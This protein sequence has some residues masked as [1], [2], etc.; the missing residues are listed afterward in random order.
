MGLGN[1]AEAR[2]ELALISQTHQNDL[3]VLNLRWE[4]AAHEADWQSGLE[5]ARTILEVAPEECEGWLHQAYALR[6]VSAGGLQAAWEALLP[7][8]EKFPD[9]PTIPYN[10]AC[11]AC[12]MEQMDQARLLLNRAIQ[13]GGKDQIKK[14][15][16][17]DSDLQAL[18]PEIR[19]Y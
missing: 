7:S 12:Q 17:H 15:A 14:M 13:V 2:A 5:I 3:P 4:L 1:L 18:W 9:V 19:S 16:L 11:Y 10:L 6:R 8:L